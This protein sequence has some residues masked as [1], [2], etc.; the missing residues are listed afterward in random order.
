MVT[1]MQDIATQDV[2]TRVTE[3]FGAQRWSF[4]CERCDHSYRTVAHPYTVAALA[5]RANGW[6]VDPTALCPGCAS[7]A[8][9][10]AA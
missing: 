8:L 10:L 2:A 6:V 1:P 7:V 5:A 3:H 4:R 9:S